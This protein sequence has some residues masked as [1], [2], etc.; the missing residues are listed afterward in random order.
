MLCFPLMWHFSL[1]SLVLILDDSVIFLLPFTQR[2]AM[3]ISIP[4]VPYASNKG[5]GE[6]KTLL[7]F[8]DLPDMLHR[9]HSTLT[10]FRE[11]A[12]AYRSSTCGTGS[13]STGLPWP[14]SCMYPNLLG[15]VVKRCGSSCLSLNIGLTPGRSKSTKV[16]TG[17]KYGKIGNRRRLI[18]RS[19]KP[20]LPPFELM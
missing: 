3:A 2:G 11:N 18:W 7:A 1:Y 19:T 14:G 15:S 4:M 20:T 16:Q 9:R 6:K 10:H 12:V 17:G 5:I 13:I 8:D